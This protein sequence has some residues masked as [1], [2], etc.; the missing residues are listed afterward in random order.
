MAEP[1]VVI[2][3]NTA[4][5]SAVTTLRREGYRGPLV[6]VGD[7]P[8]PPYQRPPLSKE[9]LRGT[10]DLEAIRY[11]DLA[12]YDEH[13]V[14]MRLGVR[15][16]RLDTAQRRVHLD[17]GSE[18]GY[19]QLLL[20]TGGRNRRP[21]IPG[22]GLEGVH[23]LR[24]V[25]DAD[26]IRAA[27]LTGR[28]AVVVGLGLVGSEVASTLRQMGLEVTAVEPQPTP[29]AALGDDI[30]RVVAELHREHGVELLL[31]DAVAAFE[32][33]ERLSAVR[34]RGGRRLPAD[35]AVVG[36]GIEPAVELARG[37]TIEVDDGI[38]VDERCRTHAPGVYA[39]G[40]VASHHHPRLGRRVRVE[41]WQHAGLQAATA[42]RNMLGAG[43]DYDEP[44]WFWTDQYDLT[45]QS[46]GTP[47]TGGREVRRGSVEER[48]VSW[49]HLD[50]ARLV[51]AVGMGRP[52]DIALAGR[53]IAAGVEVDPAHLADPT[54]RLRDLLP[55][56]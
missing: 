42:A 35:L 1:I 23:D 13:E 41:H 20:A 16:T 34:T 47:V 25:A 21:P 53:L 40:D 37:T 10:R 11:H 24:T 38:V 52:R 44:H 4:G 28:R 39:A 56:P 15:A 32:G 2:G 7:E 27:A 22:I 5:D 14:E 6:L 48:A 55:R 12:H 36:L 45:I 49:F 50:G 51:A 31:G 17:D 33:Q 46:V 9:Y 8:Q 29:L 3:A 54:V 26:A 30:G 18:L 43:E 19:Q